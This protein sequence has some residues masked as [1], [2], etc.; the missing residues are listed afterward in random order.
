[1]TPFFDYY[2]NNILKYEF[3]VKYVYKNVYQLP[4]LEKVVLSF[5]FSQTSLKVLLPVLSALT[6][7][8]SQKPYLITS[9]NLNVSLRIKAGLPVGCKVSLRG[10]QK[11]LFFEK[12]IFSSLP[13]LKGFSSNFRNNILFLSISNL[14]VFKEIEKDYEHFPNLPKLQI[15]FVFKSNSKKEIVDFLTA[16]HFPLKKR[17]KF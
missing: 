3:V 6:L 2:Y 8:S 4:K 13:R 9:K 7:I 15:A 16:F 17:L 5:S 14:F 1:M 12:L 10:K 11:F